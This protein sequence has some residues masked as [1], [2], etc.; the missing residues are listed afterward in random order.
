L[1]LSVISLYLSTIS[2]F[3]DLLILEGLEEEPPLDFFPDEVEEGDTGPEPVKLTLG[4]VFFAP[5]VAI[6]AT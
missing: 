6:C 4:G 5:L 2:D 3:L 1:I